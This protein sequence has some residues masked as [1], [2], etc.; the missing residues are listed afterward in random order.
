MITVFTYN[1]D[2][3]VEAEYRSRNKVMCSNK[4]K[5]LP[6]RYVFMSYHPGFCEG[7]DD[8]LVVFEDKS[9]FPQVL[10]QLYPPLPGQ[11]EVYT[12]RHLGTLA[13]DVLCN[14]HY[15]GTLKMRSHRKKLPSEST[16]YIITYEDNKPTEEK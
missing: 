10:K 12:F 7:F 13:A 8:H 1:R 5:K 14:G 6:G 3:R 9:E 16:R 15:I 4:F 11:T 2:T